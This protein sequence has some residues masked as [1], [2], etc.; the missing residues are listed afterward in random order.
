MEKSR[1]P[2]INKS[3]VKGWN[4]G[5]KLI[6]WKDLKWKITIKMMWTLWI[7]NSHAKTPIPGKPSKSGLIGVW[8][9]DNLYPGTNTIGNGKPSLNEYWFANEKYKDDAMKPVVLR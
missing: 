5:K 4:Q 9:K 2:I 3:N 1:S 7:R 8:H 6:T